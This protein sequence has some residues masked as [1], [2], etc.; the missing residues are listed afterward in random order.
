MIGFFRGKFHAILFVALAVTSSDAFSERNKYKLEQFALNEISRI[1]VTKHLKGFH[2]FT[3]SDPDGYIYTVIEGD[4]LGL[5]SGK[6]ISITEDEIVVEEI[7]LND[8]GDW[9]SRLVQIMPSNELMELQK[10]IK[11]NKQK[12]GK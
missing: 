8:N 12:S 1:L 10:S 6:V 4:Y 11:N 7:Y 3:A 5:N 9:D 2:Y